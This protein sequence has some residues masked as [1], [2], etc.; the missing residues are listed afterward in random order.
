MPANQKV[1][2]SSLDDNLFFYYLLY[3]FFLEYWKLSKQNYLKHLSFSVISLY[4]T[5]VIFWY[6]IELIF[7][8]ILFLFTLLKKNII[9]GWFESR[10]F[11]T[12]DQR[13]DHYT[14]LSWLCKEEN[15]LWYNIFKI[16]NKTIILQ[17][18]FQILNFQIW[19]TFPRCGCS[20]Y[21]KACS[22]PTLW[23]LSS[24]FG[25]MLEHPLRGKGIK[26]Q[27]SVYY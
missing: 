15:Y 6:H 5:S 26:H 2:G 11:R 17:Q 3:N 16:I 9:A 10:P 27:C 22:R 19:I 12:E 24:H 8:L 20:R 25:R 18:K 13:I 7:Y 1:P 21:L 4:N 23:V 14:N